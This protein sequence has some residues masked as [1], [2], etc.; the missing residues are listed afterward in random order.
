[1]TEPATRHGTTSP[2]PSSSAD[3][4]A[5][6]PAGPRAP[7][8][9]W[10][11]EVAVPATP[12]AVLEPVIGTVRYARLV[13]AAAGFRD[14]LG[15]RTIWNVNST[16]V[17]GGVAEMLQVL[18]GYIEGLDIAVRWMVIGGDPEF[19]AITKRLHNQIH[20]KAGGGPLNSADASHYEHV[21][22]ANADELLRQVCEGDIV[23]LH[24]PQTAGLAAPLARPGCGWCGAV[25]SAWTGGTTLRARHG[26][27]C[28]HTWHPRTHSCSPGGS[29]CR[30]GLLRNKPGSSRHRSTRSP[31]RTSS[32]TPPPYRRSW[33]PSGSWT[34]SRPRHPG[35]SRAATERPARSPAPGW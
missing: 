4:F 10:L 23:L 24:D 5:Q 19:F 31:R 7:E 13:T 33:P 26:I 35:A 1:M 28:S 32:S 30:R 27:S 25:T 17:G 21:L 29:T 15:R 20:G 12:V 9:R 3:G 8:P 2:Q 14:R 18:M 16:A 6:S 22:A 11:H 34:A